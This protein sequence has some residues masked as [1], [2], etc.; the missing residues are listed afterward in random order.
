[1]CQGWL[2]SPFIKICRNK[3]AAHP[4]VSRYVMN[5]DS[6][7]KQASSVNSSHR[8]WL[9]YKHTG[10]PRL[11]ER[12]QAE[13]GRV[14]REGVQLQ[15]HLCGPDLSSN[16]SLWLPQE[17]PVLQSLPW[18]LLLLCS[19]P[20]FL[21]LFLYLPQLLH[22]FT[23]LPQSCLSSSFISFSSHPP[24]VMHVENVSFQCIMHMYLMYTVRL[25]EHVLLLSDPSVSGL[26]QRRW[27]V[28][29]CSNRERKSKSCCFR[30]TYLSNHSNKGLAN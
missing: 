14:E 29:K 26:C 2:I 20:S 19:L 11:E 8:L 30:Q 7:N 3:V 13:Q 4:G 24:W 23:P 15:N 12:R 10:C 5:S 22:T 16:P 6:V 25:Q 28:A 18:C 21:W 1:M 17:K 9:E 27:H